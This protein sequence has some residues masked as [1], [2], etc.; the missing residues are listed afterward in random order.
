MTSGEEILG[1]RILSFSRQTSTLSVFLAEHILLTR[2]AAIIE[3]NKQEKDKNNANFDKNLDKIIVAQA[4]LQHPNISLLYQYQPANAVANQ[5][6]S[7][8]KPVGN[9]IIIREWVEGQT[10]A[11]VLQAQGTNKAV[12]SQERA[13]NIFLQLLD[14]LAYAHHKGIIHAN[15]SAENIIIDK[16]DKVKITDFGISEAQTSAYQ[17]PEV[18]KKDVLDKRSDIYSLGAIYF[19]LLTGKTPATDALDIKKINPKIDKKVAQ[20]ILKSTLSDSYKRYQTCEEIRSEFFR[21]ENTKKTNYKGTIIMLGVGAAAVGGAVWF[22]KNMLNQQEKVMNSVPLV[23][24]PKEKIDSSAYYQKI[25]DEQNK[26]NKE[27]KDKREKAKKDSLRKVDP[28]EI[29]K[30]SLEKVEKFEKEALEKRIKLRKETLMKNLLIDGQFISNTAGEYKVK[31]EIFNRNTDAEFTDLKVVVSYFNGAG[32][33]IEKEEKFIEKIGKNAGAEIEITKK[34]NATRFSC[35]LLDVKV[36]DE[37]PTEMPK[38]NLPKEIIKE[39]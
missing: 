7:T 18:I 4:R 35:K 25:L 37:V 16:N 27:N 8:E 5:E 12:M 11:Q 21:T 39:N 32:E 28:E 6:K 22:G 26:N 17:S 36:I 14:A 23:I 9:A 30:D 31:V 33:V 38:E 19:H 2:K 1:Y 24:K 34:V 20:I 13:K 29:R 10:L 15:L 3:I